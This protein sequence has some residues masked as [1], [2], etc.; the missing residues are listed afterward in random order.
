MTAKTTQNDTFTAGETPS[1]QLGGRPT[2]ERSSLAYR[3]AARLEL[4]APNAWCIG[5]SAGDGRIWVESS[6][7]TALDQAARY[8]ALKAAYQ[9]ETGK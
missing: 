7:E 2:R 5:V 6:V 1:L 4:G 8:D 9:Q 3:I